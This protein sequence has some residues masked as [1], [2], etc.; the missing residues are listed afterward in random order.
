MVLVAALLVVFTIFAAMTI[1]RAYMGL[2]RTELRVGADAA[3]KAG[4]EALAR[5]D[6]ADDARSAAIDVAAQNRLAGKPLRLSVDD[7]LLGRMAQAQSARWQFS[8]D[9]QPFNAVQINA[10]SGPDAAN[11]AVPLFFGNTTGLQ[12][13]T[14]SRSSVAGHKKVAICLALDR[15]GSMLF[16]MS[17]ES[18]SYPP[19]NPGLSDF[20]AWGESW[21]NHLSPPHPTDSRWAVLADAVDLF[22]EEASKHSRPPQTGLVTWA[23]NY[24]MPIPPRTQFEAATVDVPVPF[25]S[26]ADWQSNRAA[27]RTAVRRLG[28]QPMMGATNLSAGLDAAVADLTGPRAESHTEKVVILMTDGEWNEGRSPIAAARD[29][30]AAEI[31]V[32]TVTML[33]AYQ[34]DVEQVARITGGR[35]YTTNDAAQLQAAFEELARSLQVVLVD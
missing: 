10:R 16:D 8:A 11:P 32:H 3:A 17:G 24:Q 34:P 29:A 6:S 28:N 26:L 30:A 14:P 20:T 18:F 5:T 19:N 31:V 12:H 13:F 4:A 25:G 2:A 27:I 33:T 35:H 22:L 9:E 15:S 23:S 1:D 21:Q 7:I